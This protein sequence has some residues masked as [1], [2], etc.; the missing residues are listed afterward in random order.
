MKTYKGYLIDLDGTMYNGTEK[1]EEACEFVR[2]LK[3]RGVP[4]LFVTNNSSRTPKQVADKL[5]SFDIPATEEQVFTTSMATAQHIAQQKK[6]ASVYVI[7]EE[8]IRQAIEEN[9]LTFGGE[10]ADFVVVGIDRSIT[11]EKFAVG[12]LAIRNGAALFPLTEILRF[13][14]REGSCRETAH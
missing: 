9:G 12:C 1:I 5:V 13:R 4:Y 3:D 10:N 7:G 6:D 8:G 14:L 2:T 11:Y